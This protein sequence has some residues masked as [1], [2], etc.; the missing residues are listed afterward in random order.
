MSLHIKDLA[1][2][3]QDG[4][5]LLGPLSLDLDA[6]QQWGLVGESG[7]GKSLLIRALF[8]VLPRGVAQVSGSIQAWGTPMD[9]PSP[10]RD[11]IRGRRL[12]WVPQDPLLALN[13]LLSVQEQ[14]TLLPAA[15]L[16]E[17]PAASL[18]RLRPLLEQLRMRSDAAFLRRLPHELSGGQ[19]QRL[20]L[21]MALSCDPELLVLDEPTTAL[22]PLVQ[23]DFIALM[24]E[25][26]QVR[27]FG[28]LWVSHDL[29]VL[30]ATCTHLA[31]LCG[32]EIVE[33]APTADLLSAPR[34]T[35]VARLIQAARQ[36]GPLANSRP[37]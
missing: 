30:A 8:G 16:G 35:G 26:H 34:H 33:A 18:S 36:E 19:R 11:R 2:T 25:L 1:L 37:A 29:S 12:G 13:P 32:G 20:C 10:D 28:W 31:V 22:D 9:I 4:T 17:A 7:T 14:L 27:P 23:A 6:G 3:G 15:H 21:A 5:Q 24:L